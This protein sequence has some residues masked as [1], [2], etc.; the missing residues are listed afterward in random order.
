MND[1]KKE[2]YGS[3]N[4]NYLLYAINFVLQHK[5]ASKIRLYMLKIT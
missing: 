1:M 4:L 2:K 5:N 3:V